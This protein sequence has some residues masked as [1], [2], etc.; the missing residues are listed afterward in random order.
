VT[1]ASLV[2]VWRPETLEK[3]N[4]KSTRAGRAK[5]GAGQSWISWSIYRKWHYIQICMV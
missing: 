3:K 4:Q 2:A 5:W 1:A